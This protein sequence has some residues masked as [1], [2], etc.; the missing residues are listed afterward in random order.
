MLT[1]AYLGRKIGAYI[2]IYVLIPLLDSSP[3]NYYRLS[4][5][6]LETYTDWKELLK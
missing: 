5:N 2:Y 1:T 3:N 6:I 4:E